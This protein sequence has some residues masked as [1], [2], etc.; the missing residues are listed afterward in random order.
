L[1]RNC[2]IVPVPTVAAHIRQRGYDHTL[3][4]AKKLAKLQGLPLR[5]PLYRVTSSKQRGE[6]REN[7]RVQASKAFAARG[8]LDPEAIYLLIDD[9]ITTGATLRYAAKALAD[10]GAREIWAGIIAR[11]PLD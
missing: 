10:A 1:P 7:H 8:V 4:I 11:Q 5:R 9:V 2:I 3:L 6:N